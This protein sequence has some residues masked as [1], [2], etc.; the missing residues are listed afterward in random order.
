[1]RLQPEARL[2]RAMAS[3][4]STGRLVR[5][6]AD[7]LEAIPRDR[8]GGRLQRSGVI[9]AGHAVAAVAAA[10]EKAA[11]LHGGDAAVFREAGLDLH[12]DRM[13]PPVR[14]EDFLARERD[15]YRPPRD[16]GQL[17]GHQLV[18]EDVALAAQA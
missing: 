5:E 10:V 12:Q 11:E 6:Q 7:T 16:D 13:T 4:R 18:R 17:G 3:F 9:G 8:I 1:M 15:L 2:R 14:V